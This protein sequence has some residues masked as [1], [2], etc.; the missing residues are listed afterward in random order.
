M[1]SQLIV[2]RLATAASGK[3]LGVVPANAR[4]KKL[5]Q[6]QNVFCVSF[7]AKLKRKIF[8]ENILEL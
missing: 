8:N 3:P 4:Y 1:F 2:R 6:L 7:F 5:Q